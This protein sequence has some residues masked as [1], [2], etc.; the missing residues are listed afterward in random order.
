TPDPA[1]TAYVAFF[2]MKPDRTTSV[3]L[4]LVLLVLITLII[5][6]MLLMTMAVMDVA[7]WRVTAIAAFSFCMLFV[8]SASKLAPIGGIIALIVGYGLDYEGSFQIGEIATRGLLYAWLFVGIP[9]GVSIAVNLVLGPAPRRLV[10]QEL[11]RR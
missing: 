6:S 5:G 7:F 3:I 1:L 10:E 8:A 9:A 2:M 4:S 11:A